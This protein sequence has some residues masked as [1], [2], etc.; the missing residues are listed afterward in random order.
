MQGA[1]EPDASSP[2]NLQLHRKLLDAGMQNHQQ[3]EKVNTFNDR[4]TVAAVPK[5]DD[6]PTKTHAQNVFSAEGASQGVQPRRMPAAQG[7]PGGISDGPAGQEVDSV[8]LPPADELTKDDGVQ[9]DA[10]RD[11]D[12]LLNAAQCRSVIPNVG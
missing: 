5:S 1:K 9:H 7:V 3:E 11:N 6:Q 4:Q 8:S 2:L 10:R 12:E